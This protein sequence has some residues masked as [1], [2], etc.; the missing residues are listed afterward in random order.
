MTAAG[1]RVDLDWLM[2]DL[3]TRLS[4]VRHA[5]ALSS[6]GLLMG[7]SESVGRDDAEHLA[8]VASGFQ[9]LSRG[10][11]RHFRGGQVR[12]TLVE[13]DEFCLVVTAAGDNSCLVV[14][15]D[16]ES[17]L[18]TVAYEMN[19]LA[20]KV[21]GSLVANPLPTVREPVREP[22]TAPAGEPTAGP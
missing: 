7:R 8:A 16:A 4:G 11:S 21:R 3:V 18:G 20:R 15:A 5:V 10:A 17:D 6:D 13:T 19:L 22:A 9:G 12:Q 1:S 14:L 2:Q